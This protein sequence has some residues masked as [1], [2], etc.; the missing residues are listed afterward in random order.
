MSRGDSHPIESVGHSPTAS[1]LA[2]GRL[3]VETIVYWQD[4]SHRKVESISLLEGERAR[5]RVSV[6]IT[7]PS[8]DWPIASS[9]APSPPHPQVAIPVTT[10]AKVQMRGLDAVDDSGRVLPVLGRVDNGLLSVAFLAALL[11]AERDIAADAA[12]W[13][14]L[15]AVVMQPPPQATR[16]AQELITRHGLAST[17]SEQYLLRLAAEFIFFVLL[18]ADLVGSRTVVKYAYHWEFGRQFETSSSRMR[19][20]YDKLASGLGWAPRAFTMELGALDTAKSYHLEIPAPPGLH[21]LAL[22]VPGLTGRESHDSAISTLAH[23]HGEVSQEAP[24][25]NA[26]LEL[27]QDPAGLHRTVKWAAIFVTV[28]LGTTGLHLGELSRDVGT[29][30]TLLLFGPALLLTLLFHPG[31]SIVVSKVVGGLRYV[32]VL[33]SAILFVAGL[34]LALRVDDGLLA[35][36]W[37]VATTM[38]AAL[39]ILLGVG[40]LRIVTRARRTTQGDAQ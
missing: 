4:W 1:E 24:A 11:H 25:V 22:D 15:K 37:F 16:S 8:I 23:V 2:T 5:R 26:T 13:E 29:P 9:A 6:D 27:E 40:W 28:L 18:P 39:A 38:S 17:L 20:M 31:E 35:A 14:Y 32:A 21:V 10:I 34:L 19:G 3:L 7:V 12:L 36:S 33:L 30:V